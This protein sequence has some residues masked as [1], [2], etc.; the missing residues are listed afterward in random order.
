M[1]AELDALAI[2]HL[3]EISDKGIQAMVNAGSIGVV[4]PTTAYI[5]RIK[6][7]PVRKMINSGMAVAL[8]SDYNPNAHCSSMVSILYKT[9]DKYIFELFG[10]RGFFFF[11]W[12]Y[13]M[14]FIGRRVRA[15]LDIY[16]IHKKEKKPDN[17]FDGLLCYIARKLSLDANRCEQC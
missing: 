8:G 16:Y 3:E 11:F 6:P 17:R 5:L 1:G 4:L 15:V 13:I 7:P 2:S 9:Y 14:R 12:A 10:F